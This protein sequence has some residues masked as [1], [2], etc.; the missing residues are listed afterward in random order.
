MDKLDG[1][2]Q[3]TF[4]VRGRKLNFDEITKRLGISPT[5]THR[6]GDP[7]RLKN[8]PFPCDAW[9]LASPLALNE[10]LDA[11]LKWL[12]DRLRPNY[13]Y[14]KV[15]K[16]QADLSIYW[17]YIIEEEQNDLVVSS[18]ALGIFTALGIPLVV[19][20]LII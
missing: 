14:I 5:T 15:L 8:K 13:A 19:S 1:K 16:E 7:S 3:V 18:E 4:S 12:A 20:I 17:S 2:N 9:T 6:A 11:H 10:S